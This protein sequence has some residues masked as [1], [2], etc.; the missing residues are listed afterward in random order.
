MVKASGSGGE[1]S[2]MIRPREEHSGSGGE[3][4]E[5]HSGIGGESSAS[6]EPSAEEIIRRS[7]EGIRKMR[8]KLEKARKRRNKTLVRAEKQILKRS[9][10]KSLARKDL[11]INEANEKLARVHGRIRTHFMKKCNPL[12]IRYLRTSLKD[13]G[14]CFKV[15]I[16]LL[17]A[18]LPPD[19]P[20]P[21]ARVSRRRRRQAHPH[22]VSNPAEVSAI[23]PSIRGSPIMIE[24]PTNLPPETKDEIYAAACSM[25]Y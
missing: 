1:S 5:E 14:H 16:G 17:P 2:A 21:A 19:E 4:S 24:C 23:L 20:A 25:V 12:E 15:M 9:G 22:R 3:N 11:I 13:T 18:L 6:E 7:R 10:R 8:E